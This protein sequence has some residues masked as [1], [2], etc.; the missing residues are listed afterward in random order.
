M[1][2]VYAG[3]ELEPGLAEVLHGDQAVDECMQRLGELSL[4]TLPAGAFG[5]RPLGL[6]KI[7]R[8][9]DLL[10]ELRPQFEYIIRS[11][12]SRP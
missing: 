4:W 8:L 10:T 11:S 12:S 7:Q 1:Q 2:H 3:I 9:G 6:S 5:D